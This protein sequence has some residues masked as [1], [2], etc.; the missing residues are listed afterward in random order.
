[1]PDPNVRVIGEIEDIDGRVVKVG[2]DYDSVSIAFG[3]SD[4]HLGSAAAEEF[5]QLFVSACWQAAR[6][7][8]GDG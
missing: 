8:P 3:S 2:V 1:M 6:Q 4:C 7:V 5:A